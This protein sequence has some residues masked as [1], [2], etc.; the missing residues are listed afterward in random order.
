MPLVVLCKC[1]KIEVNYYIGDLLMIRVCNVTKVFLIAGLTSLIALN[2]C[3]TNSLQE[4]KKLILA[5]E[6]ALPDFVRAAPPDIQEAYRFA[7]ANPEIV[8]AFPCYC[9]CGAMGHNSN[10]NCYLAGERPGEEITFDNH[11]L[12]CSIC[13]DISQDVMR[14][15]DQGK[16]VAEIYAYVDNAYAR[17]GP[18]TSLEN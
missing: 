8:S 11:A 3:T 2:A 10:Y 17:F 18:A 4:H 7:I 15:L 13:V 5:P 12:G 14:M 16:D 1:D 9:G 6:K